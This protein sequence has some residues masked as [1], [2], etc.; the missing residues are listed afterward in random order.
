MGLFGSKKN[1]NIAGKTEKTEKKIYTEIKPEPQTDIPELVKTE[2]K[3]QDPELV[4]EPVIQ[5]F[6]AERV[7]EPQM[8][9]AE[10]AEAEARRISVEHEQNQEKKPLSD[11]GPLPELDIP[12]TVF[13]KE[14]QSA[15]QESRDYIAILLKDLEEVRQENE[16]LRI[17]KQ[18]KNPWKVLA[19]I[20]SLV[21]VA[22]LVCFLWFYTFVYR[23]AIET[24][25]NSPVP[26]ATPMLTPDA[27][28]T[29]EEE[30]TYII[31]DL[32]AYVAGLPKDAVAKFKVSAE[33]YF[34]YA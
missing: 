23:K 27:Q 9:E 16:R 20:L 7:A 8:K 11:T 12:D 24:G 4:T 10:P 25:N 19:V 22:G 1:K 6:E 5:E 17:P 29:P 31:K 32:T 26:T 18:E 14:P 33:E 3:Q 34:G 28:K 30:T 13:A 2:G 21:I 15:L